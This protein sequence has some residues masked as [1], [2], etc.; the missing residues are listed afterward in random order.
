MSHTYDNIILST[1][2]L[3]RNSLTQFIVVEAMNV[4]PDDTFTVSVF[5]FDWSSGSARFIRW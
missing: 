4:D 1:G 2:V 3:R 5:M